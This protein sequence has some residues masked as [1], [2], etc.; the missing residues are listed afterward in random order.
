MNVW[1]FV[2]KTGCPLAS[3]GASCSICPQNLDIIRIK[4][5]IREHCAADQYDLLDFRADSIVGRLLMLIMKVREVPTFIIGDKR[6][7]SADEVISELGCSQAASGRT[8]A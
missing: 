7:H 2:R 3:G 5:W 8:H 1:A 6:L 4:L